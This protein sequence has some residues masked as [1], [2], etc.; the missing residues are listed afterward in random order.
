[1]VIG[2]LHSKKEADEEEIKKEQ[3][4]QI[5]TQERAEKIKRTGQHPARPDQGQPPARAARSRQG[6]RCAGPAMETTG[7]DGYPQGRRCSGPA[8]ATTGGGARA[9]LPA[10]HGNDGD[11]PEEGEAATA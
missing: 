1:M 8:M 7:S 3:N 5:E 2:A 11:R 6:R 4:K 10:S 9:L